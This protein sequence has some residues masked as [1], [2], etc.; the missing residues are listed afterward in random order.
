MQPDVH[1]P[2]G[3]YPRAI[4]PGHIMDTEAKVPLGHQLV[5]PGIKPAVIPVLEDIIKTRGQD[6]NKVSEPVNIQAPIGRKLK[7][8][9]AQI[10][11]QQ[12]RPVD[13]LGH[14]LGRVLEPFHVSDEPAGLHGEDESRW[15]HGLPV[16][17][18]RLFR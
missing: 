2:A 17:K 10:I 1:Q 3:E 8:D 16:S 12:L 5:K 9:R 4:K 7:K 11:P 6:I 18:R 15:H 13:K 14:R